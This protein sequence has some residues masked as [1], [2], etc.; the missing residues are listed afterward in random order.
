MRFFG[1]VLALVSLNI[2]AAQGEIVS[3]RASPTQ[4][5]AVQAH[6]KID[7]RD[8]DVD[9]RVVKPSTVAREMTLLVET[10]TGDALTSAAMARNMT[11]AQIDVLRL[12]EALR[13][14]ALQDLIDKLKTDSGAHHVLVHGDV[15][16]SR[17]LI[18]NAARID[19]LLLENESP[20]PSLKT[21]RMITLIGVDGFKQTQSALIASASEPAN[22]RRFYLAGAMLTAPKVVSSCMAPVNALSADPARRA[23]LVVLDDWIRGAKPPASRFPGRMDIVPARSLNWPAAP[24]LSPP[25]DD[26][27]AVKIDPDGNETSGLRMPDQALPIATFTGF[28]KTREKA[29]NVCDA[30]A[31]FPF[32]AT[33]A[34]REASKDPRLSLVERY[35]SRAYFVATLRVIA[36][37]LVREKLLLPSDADAYVAAG[38]VAPF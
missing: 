20:P 15:A 38:K 17:T 7:G 36:D 13:G 33:R 29:T 16:A 18:E 35:G 31:T 24:N 37:K 11:L 5:C 1:V 12:P 22:Q 10:G 4:A 2:S 34:V 28:N 3:W 27:P 23:T 26:R 30:G 21:P 32:A 9:L 8:L 25:A 19:G 6:L 14:K